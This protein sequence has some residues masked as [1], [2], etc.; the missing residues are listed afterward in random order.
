MVTAKGKSLTYWTFPFKLFNKIRQD[1]PSEKRV[2]VP[3]PKASPTAHKAQVGEEWRD[4]GS[5]E[6]SN[7]IPKSY[8]YDNIDESRKPQS[9]GKP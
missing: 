2:S 7:T 4:G 5:M 6:P 1:S 3:F 9:C 8:D